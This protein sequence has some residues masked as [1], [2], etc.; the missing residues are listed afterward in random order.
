MNN[1]KTHVAILKL[2]ADHVYLL[3]VGMYE[4]SVTRQYA[5]KGGP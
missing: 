3:G 2:M 4:G 5:D 1:Q